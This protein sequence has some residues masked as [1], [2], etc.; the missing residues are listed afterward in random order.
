M[1]DSLLYHDIVNA[2]YGS[3]RVVEMGNPKFDGIFENIQKK[4][5]PEGWKKILWGEGVKRVILWTTDHGVHDGKIT[6]DVTLDL[7]GKHLF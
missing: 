1:F 2:G 5:I 7:Y 6:E 4:Q 3:D